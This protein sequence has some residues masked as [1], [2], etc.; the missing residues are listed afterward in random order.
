MATTKLT[1]GGILLYVEAF[2]R[3]TLLIGTLLNCEIRWSGSRSQ[4]FSAVCIP[5]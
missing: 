1:D 2:C 4:G 5:D 3:S